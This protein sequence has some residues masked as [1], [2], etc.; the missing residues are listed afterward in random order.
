MKWAIW[1]FSVI[2]MHDNKRYHKIELEQKIPKSKSGSG[3][4]ESHVG[5]QIMY[6]DSNS[7]GSEEKGRKCDF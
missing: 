3:V 2:S 4:R 5:K 7:V 6:K 1:I